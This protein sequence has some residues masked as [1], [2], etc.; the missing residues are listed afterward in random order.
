VYPQGSRLAA[1]GTSPG[2]GQVDHRLADGRQRAVLAQ[3]L[4]GDA[5]ALADEAEQ[6]VLGADVIV[7]Q[8]EGLP[9]R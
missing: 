8:L 2:R 6:D 4:D 9:E 3:D 7:V 5:V 1:P